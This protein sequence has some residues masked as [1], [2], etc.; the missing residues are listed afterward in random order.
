MKRRSKLFSL[1]NF[2]LKP[3]MH[4]ALTH[5]LISRYIFKLSRTFS[6]FPSHWKLPSQQI[7]PRNFYPLHCP[8]ERDLYLH[9]HW[10]V[11][12]NCN[13]KTFISSQSPSSS[14]KLPTVQKRLAGNIWN[15]QEKGK[16]ETFQVNYFTLHL[17]FLYL[18]R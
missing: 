3:F 2:S 15:H 9:N 10:E 16:F 18:S 11:C 1:S 4:P 6:H 5:F 12:N 14:A 7:Y 17:F 8:H 13:T